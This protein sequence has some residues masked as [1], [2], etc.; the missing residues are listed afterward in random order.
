MKIKIK[1]DYDDK[2][3]ML[4]GKD[5]KV[6]ANTEFNVSNPEEMPFERAQLLISSGYAEIIEEKEDSKPRVEETKEDSKFKKVISADDESPSILDK[7]K[8]D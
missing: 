3:L 1:K 7:K 6:I 2:Y 5:K 4:L 8:E